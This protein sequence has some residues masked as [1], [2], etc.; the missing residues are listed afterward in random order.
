[1]QNEEA[2][3]MAKLI[4]QSGNSK[5]HTKAT[6]QDYSA[7]AL[8]IGINALLENRHASTPTTIFKAQK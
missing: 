5:V 8:T 3:K 6:A 1:M 7:V 4:L 2:Q